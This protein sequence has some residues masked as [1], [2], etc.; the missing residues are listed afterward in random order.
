MLFEERVSAIGGIGPVLESPNPLIGGS[1]TCQV[2]SDIASGYHFNALTCEGCKGFFRRT[3]KAQKQFRCAYEG[4]CKI[5]RNNRRQ[6]QA[7]RIEKCLMIGMKKECIMSDDQIR[8]K[9]ELIQNNRIKRIQREIPELS[10]EELGRL[11]HIERAFSDASEQNTHQTDVDIDFSRLVGL[12]EQFSPVRRSGSPTVIKKATNGCIEEV[13]LAQV[14]FLK[15]LGQLVNE[16]AT[17]ARNLEPFERLSQNDQRALL[18]GAIAE[19]VHIKMNK[20]FDVD[21]NEFI[22][23]KH[24]LNI[25]ESLIPS[26]LIE[27]IYRFHHRMSSQKVDE[28]VVAILCAITLFSPDRPGVEDSNAVEEIQHELT[29][30]LQ[31]YITGTRRKNISSFAT[32]LNLLVII[33]PI[34]SL[35]RL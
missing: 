4:K 1:K 32:L 29:C 7:C 21:A 23:S 15:T 22:I 13:N 30:L 26:R 27:E 8:R 10:H 16:V 12:Y 25:A 35:M 9:R 11:N 6:C 3:M 14:I 17:F 28:S 31:S 5:D 34:S 19:L 2:C 33:R 24:S 18:N 20:L